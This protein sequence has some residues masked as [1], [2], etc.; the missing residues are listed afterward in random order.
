MVHT[1]LEHSLNSTRY[2][3][4]KYFFFNATYVYLPSFQNHTRNL[5]EELRYAYTLPSCLS[6]LP[7]H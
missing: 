5:G 7:L 6:Y 1:N 2:A 4:T 3:I